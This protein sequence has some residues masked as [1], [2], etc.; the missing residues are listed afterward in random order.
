MFEQICYVLSVMQAIRMNRH[1]RGR[2]PK[3][4]EPSGPVT[5]TLPK[6]VLEQ[7][8]TI[9][10]DRAKAIV[11]AVEAIV[12]SGETGSRNVYVVEMAHG[13]GVVVVPPNRSLRSIPW[14]KMIELTPTQYL[15]AL[16]P[17]TPIEKLEV[18]LLDLMQDAKKAAP[19]DVPMLEALVERI[20]DLRR[21]RKLSVAQILFVD[22]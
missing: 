15:I 21:R 6:R 1:G 2:P 13:T 22:I 16:V 12:D 8:R 7:L 5:V 10:G 4:E 11:K 19:E 14:L 9:D 17:D 18:A 20:G 3:F